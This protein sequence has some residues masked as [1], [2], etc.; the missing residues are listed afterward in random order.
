[1]SRSQIRDAITTISERR[2]A[3][4]LL[5]GGVQIADEPPINESR[6]PHQDGRGTRLRVD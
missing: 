6:V 4:M 2:A 3:T 1:M 5:M